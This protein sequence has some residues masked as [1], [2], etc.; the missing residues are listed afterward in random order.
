MK[1][2]FKKKNEKKAEKEKDELTPKFTSALLFAAA[3]PHSYFL[4]PIIWADPCSDV[5][6]RAFEMSVTWIAS[7]N[8]LEG[9]A[10]IALGYIDYKT[11]TGNTKDLIDGMRKK[12]LAFAKFAFIMAILTLFLIDTP[13]PNAVLPLI[14]GSAWTTLKIGTQ[15][16]FKLT[17]DQ[18][19]VPRTFLAMYN[20]AFLIGIWYKLR[21]A[22]DEKLNLEFSFFQRVEGIMVNMKNIMQDF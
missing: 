11:I 10:G 14:I 7:L 1:E 22:R 15:I 9:A 3:L 13:S 16:S 19:F 8:A 6:F 2:S 20:L 5:F 17:P 4:Y 12:R 18:F 21:R